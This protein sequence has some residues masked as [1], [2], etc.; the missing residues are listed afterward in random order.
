MKGGKAEG[1]KKAGRS[2][3]VKLMSKG[4]KVGRKKTR[5][6]QREGRGIGFHL[7][8]TRGPS[9]PTVNTWNRGLQENSGSLAKR[10]TGGGGSW[11][12]LS[13]TGKDVKVVRKR[14]KLYGGEKKYMG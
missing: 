13:C 1:D 3:E 12:Q 5:E 2:K 6:E 14:F 10:K 4:G 9:F 11:W 7:R 8:A